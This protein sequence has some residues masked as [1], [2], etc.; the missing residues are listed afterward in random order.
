M[1]PVCQDS[2]DGNKETHGLKAELWCL[3]NKTHVITRL[4]T[5]ERQ[6]ERGHPQLYQIKTKATMRQPAA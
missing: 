1:A 5:I 6:E 3:K 2:L 4:H